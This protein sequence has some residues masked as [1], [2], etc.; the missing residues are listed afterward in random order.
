MLLLQENNK[1]AIDSIIR[2]SDLHRY[3]LEMINQKEIPLTEELR[4]IKNYLELEQKRVHL[5]AP[6]TYVI[7]EYDENASKVMIPPMILHPLVENAVK[8]CG[9]DPANLTQ[10]QI[11]IGLKITTNKAVISIENSIGL[12]FTGDNIGFKRGVEIVRETIA[13]YNKMGQHRIDFHSNLPSKHF[14]PGFL[15]ELIV[16]V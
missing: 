3:F 15:C 9:F 12:Q 7:S 1:E 14:K 6:F 11:Q 16:R 13:I 4:F 2:F 10:A 5:D 8:Y